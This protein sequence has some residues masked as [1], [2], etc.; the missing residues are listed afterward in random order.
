MSRTLPRPRSFKPGKSVCEITALIWGV[1]TG[2][3][4]SVKQGAYSSAA[5][6]LVNAQ[7]NFAEENFFESYCAFAK[8]MFGRPRVT[9]KSRSWQVRC[10]A[11]GALGGLRGLA[12]QPLR[13]GLA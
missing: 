12:S 4:S 9:P 13:A 8:K 11:P 1:A 2:N 10:V 7:R 5:K 3:F 6:K